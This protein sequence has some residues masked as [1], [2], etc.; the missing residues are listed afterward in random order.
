MRLNVTL[1]NILFSLGKRALAHERN[2]Q[3][4][5]Q[6]REIWK[7]LFYIRISAEGP[8]IVSIGWPVIG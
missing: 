8:C 5:V 6:V 7:Y 4:Q 1:C 2:S 3:N